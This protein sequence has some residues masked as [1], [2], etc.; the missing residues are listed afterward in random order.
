MDLDEPQDSPS[1]SILRSKPSPLEFSQ[2]DLDRRAAAAKA[3]AEDEAMIMYTS[4]STGFPKGGVH[5]QR[6]VGTAMKIGE[7]AAKVKPD[8]DGV[9]LKALKEFLSSADGKGF[10]LV[11][12]DAQCMPQDHP[13]GSRSAEDTKSFS[14]MLSNVNMLFLGT[15]VLVM[16]DLLYISR[17]WVSADPD[18]PGPR[19]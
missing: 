15:S 2:G 14:T 19:R 11:W 1:S 7:L 3:K 10:P 13:E 12:I 17:F 6:S 8:P 9:Q 5:T 4:G 18:L 16:L